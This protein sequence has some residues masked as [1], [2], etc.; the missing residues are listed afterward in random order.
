[1]RYLQL[2]QESSLSDWVGAHVRCPN[3]MVDRITPRPAPGADPLIVI[4]ENYIQWVIEDDFAARRPAWERVGVQMVESVTPYEEAKIRML[5][6]S[7][8]C[9]AWAGSILKLT[10][11]HES[12]RDPRVKQWVLGYLEDVV[13]CL[14]PEG[15]PSPIALNAYRD[16]VLERFSNCEIRDTNQRV[17]EDG[18]SKLAGFI[19]P[20]IA[21]RLAAGAGID[22]VAVLPALF[23][24]FLQRWKDRQLAFAHRDQSMDES[25]ARAICSSRDPVAALCGRVSIFGAVAGD[26]RLVEAVRAAFERVERVE[27]LI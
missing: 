20:T 22:K 21:D 13:P 3:S 11:V 14:S 9:L 6:G 7:H 5:N 4:S 12:I 1:M 16:A 10:F 18:A 26:A 23:L 15:R 2:A 24:R 25:E 19:A 17:A 8:S 27:R